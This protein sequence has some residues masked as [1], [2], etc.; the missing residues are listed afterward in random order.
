MTLKLLTRQLTDT[1]VMLGNGQ[2]KGDT[3]EDSSED[4]EDSK[5]FE[6]SHDI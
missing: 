2:Q 5:E 3:P 1:L 6:D 4:S